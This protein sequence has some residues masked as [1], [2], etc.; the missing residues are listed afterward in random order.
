MLKLLESFQRGGHSSSHNTRK[1]FNASFPVNTCHLHLIKSLKRR[2]ICDLSPVRPGLCCVGRNCTDKRITEEGE[3]KGHHC[4]GCQFGQQTGHCAGLHM[5]VSVFE[6]L[7]MKLKKGQSVFY[8]SLCV[9][10][11]SISQG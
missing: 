8:F 6:L 3:K 11:V 10:I 9:M 7:N 5:L 2:W 1:L 4:L